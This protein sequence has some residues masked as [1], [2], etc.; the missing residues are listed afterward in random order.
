MEVPPCGQAMQ[1]ENRLS[2][3]AATGLQCFLL[4]KSE[5]TSSINNSFDI[6]FKAIHKMHS[7][8]QKTFHMA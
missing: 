1:M 5:R 3:V 7:I 4:H 6:V 8:Y 2:S